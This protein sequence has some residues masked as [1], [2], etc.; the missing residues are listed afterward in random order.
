MSTSKRFQVFVSSTYRDLVDE[1]QQV[2]LALLGLGC[3]PVGPEFIPG[4]DNDSDDCWPKVRQQIDESDYVVLLLSGRYGTL[5]QSGI[6]FLHREYT[7][8]NTL[9]KP[10]LCFIRDPRYPLA[11]NK[12]ERTA[13]GVA[14]FRVFRESLQKHEHLSWD[15]TDSL[16]MSLRQYL[17]QFM[18]KHEAVGWVRANALPEQQGQQTAKMSFS[19][20][21]TELQEVKNA[22]NYPDMLQQNRSVA[23]LKQSVELTY[24]CNI[25]I[26]GNCKLITEKAS[27][28]WQDIF[29]AFVN[30]M[31]QSASE[32]RI[33]QS[34]AH[35]LEERFANTIYEQ[36][37]E[38]HAI[39]DFQ[40][41][42]T[43]LRMIRLHLR[44]MGLIRKDTLRSS[45]TRSVW[46]LTP[47]GRKALQD[48]SVVE[49]MKS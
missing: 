36:N 37:Q 40:F 25:Y 20:Q 42:D 39:N 46:Q 30:H 49:T 5:T 31:Q 43:S 1:R 17:P 7:Y 15:T 24:I 23:L 13:D 3:I 21:L 34:L 10:I 44:R 14:R 11:P 8:A 27:L 41:T 9:K 26:Q 16:I 38:V 22:L 45:R 47:I 19:E 33:K 4:F 12:K 18:D 29:T 32:D 48:L 2:F 28:L 35:F 6:S